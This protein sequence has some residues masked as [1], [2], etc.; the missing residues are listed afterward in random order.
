MTACASE[1]RKLGAGASSAQEVAQRIVS[2]LYRQ[3]GNDQTG[4]Q[5]CALIRCYLT[6]AYRELDP[7]SQDCARRTLGCGP[8]S[9]DMKCLTLFGTAGERPEWNERDRSRGYRSIPLAGKQVVSRFPI[10]SQLLQQLG[11]ELT[12]KTPPESDPIADRAERTLDVFHVAAAKGSHFLPAQEEFV[13][14]FGIESV[15]GFGGVLPSKELFT[16][17]LFSKQKISRETAELFKQLAL[18]VKLALLPFDQ[19]SSKRSIIRVGSQPG[20][21]QA[22][23]E[24]LEQLLVAHEQTNMHHALEHMR[25]HEE[26]RNRD[27]PFRQVFEEA[28]MGMIVLDEQRQVMRANRAFCNLVGCDEAELIGRGHELFTHLDDVQTNVAFANEC[29]E[30]KRTDSRFEKRY[31]GKDGQVMWVAVNAATCRIPAQR[32]NMV[33]AIVED[34]TERK[35]AEEALRLAKFSVDR[36]AD[37]VYWIDPQAKILDVNEAASLMLGYSKDELCA[38][39]VHDLNPDFQADM[40]RGFWEETKRQGTM[41]VETVHRSKN[42]RLIPIEVSINYL[43]HEGKEYHCAFVRDITERKRAEDKLRESEARLQ[44]ILDNSPGMVF[45]K[46]VEGRYLLV[47]RQFERAFHITR[48]RVVGKT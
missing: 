45:L 20:R 7:Q 12:S 17:I 15:L 23:A 14:P 33:L 27:E 30:G 9:L 28:P 10:V 48:E 18:S 13:I 4:Q 19:S 11:L 29:D 40:W 32:R 16:V 34:I 31:A 37:A 39:T 47:N 44:A 22:R 5:D 1:L 42:G 35:K 26:A 2:H 25:A 43:S 8:G 36:A 38:M 6:R 41:V 3:F 21:W 24:A 46:D